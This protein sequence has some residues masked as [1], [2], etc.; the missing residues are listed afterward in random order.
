[1]KIDKFIY[2]IIRKIESLKQGIIAY[3]YKDEICYWIC[4]NDFDFYTSDK[5]FRTLS[6]AW[7]KAAKALGIDITFV[8]CEPKEDA[9]AKLAEEDNLFLNV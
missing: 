9:L 1:M 3:A 8:Y 4:L 5:R 2:S 7:H 6:D